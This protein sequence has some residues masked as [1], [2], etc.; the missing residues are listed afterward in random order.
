MTIFMNPA[1]PLPFRA[2]GCSVR[3]MSHGQWF[4]VASTSNRKFTQEGKHTNAVYLA[5]TANAYPKLVEALRELAMRCD[6]AEG[7]RADGSN[8]QTIAASAIL[9]S[10]GELE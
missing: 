4:A 5:H 1:T 9:Q 8:I 6:G 10:L 3:A 2:E 7:V